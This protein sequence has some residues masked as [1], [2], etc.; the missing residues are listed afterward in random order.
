M[1]LSPIRIG[2]SFTLFTSEPFSNFNTP[3]GQTAEQTPQPTQDDRTMF[4][5][6]WAYH[7]TSIPIS[8]Y[9]EQLPHEMHWPPLV[10][11]LNFDLNF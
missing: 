1:F 7:L 2:L 10:V 5:P 4:W 3:L 11:I 9:V 8:Q 6:R